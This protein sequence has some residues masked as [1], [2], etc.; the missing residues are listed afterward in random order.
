MKFSNALLS[1]L[2][3][4]VTSCS[5]TPT[6]AEV[7]A[8]LSPQAY[9]FEGY[10]GYQRAVTTKSAEA[11]EW[12][13]RGLQLV[14]GFNHDAAAYA[15]ARAAIIDP[16]CAMAW[17]GIA[18]SYGVDVNNDY[19]SEREAK[20]ANV[21]ITE[22]KRLVAG[23]QS[24]EAAFIESAALRAVYPMPKDRS[25]LDASYSLRLERA[26]SEYP[27][28]ADLGTL[29]AESMMNMQR[30]NYWT[31]EGEDIQNT[32]KIIEVLEHALKQNPLHPGANHF[33]I[34]AVEASPAP[35]KGV[36]SAEVLRDLV[37]G[38]GH[39]VHM[40]SHIFINVGRYPD[41][42]L[43]N[44]LAIKADDIYFD[45]VGTPTF[46]RIYYLHNMHFL[47]YAAMMTGQ[48]DLALQAVS[49]MESEIPPAMLVD[50]ASDADALSSLRLAVYMRFGMWEELLAMPEYEPHRKVSRAMRAYMRSISFANS[51]QAAN[52]RNELQRFKKL[53]GE[54]PADWT[55]G[56]CSADEIFAVAELVA[57]GECLWREGNIELALEQLRMAV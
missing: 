1:M 56:F 5:T 4:A 16:S 28:D 6:P 23:Q 57:T 34:H 30:W 17:W 53:R 36:P 9:K 52:A 46:Y 47:T 31:P 14:Y 54:V 22:A 55:I 35:E 24:K 40:P 15:F 29:Y 44:Q 38:S 20:F 41:A 26:S 11:Q 32:N 43:A 51:G 7:A 8:E 12:F 3:L 48:L 10:G 42:V 50:R 39:L 37:P 25:E 33:Y 49:K 18:Y 2:F 13:N 21:A 19:V 27:N 45:K